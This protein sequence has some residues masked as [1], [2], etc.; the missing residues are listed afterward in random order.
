LGCDELQGYWLS[1]PI[2]A[3]EFSQ[4]YQEDKFKLGMTVSE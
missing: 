2:S 4:K 1:R 3:A